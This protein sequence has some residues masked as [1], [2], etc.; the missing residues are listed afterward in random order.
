MKLYIDIVYYYYLLTNI[1]SVFIY[2]YKISDML[3][4]HSLLL[5]LSITQT[6]INARNVLYFSLC[7]IFLFCLCASW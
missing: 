6:I 3:D 1:L 2:L 7:L 4:N 5:C